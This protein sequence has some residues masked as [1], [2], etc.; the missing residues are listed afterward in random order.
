MSDLRTELQ[1]AFVHLGHK[2]AFDFLLKTWNSEQPQWETALCRQCVTILIWWLLSI[3]ENLMAAPMNKSKQKDL[4]I[5]DDASET[6]LGIF[7]FDRT[8]F[9]KAKDRKWW[10]QL[11]RNR[12]FDVRAEINSY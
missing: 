8:L 6:V 1:G 9:G 4:I 11:R 2:K 7:G 10:M 5:Q 12:E 3:T